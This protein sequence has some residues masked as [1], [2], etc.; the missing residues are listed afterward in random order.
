MLVA[1]ARRPWRRGRRPRSPR[2]ADPSPGWPGPPGGRRAGGGQEEQRGRRLQGED[3]RRASLIGRSARSTAGATSRSVH[4]SRS[5]GALRPAADEEQRPERVAAVQG[6]VAAAAGVGDAAPVDR[7]VAEREGDDE[8]ARVRR[9]QRRPDA[10]QR[11][12]VLSLRRRPSSTVASSTPG[13]PSSSQRPP[14][15][16]RDLAAGAEAQRS[17]PAR[18]PPSLARRHPRLAPRSGSPSSPSSQQ[19]RSTPSIS[20]SARRTVAGSA[21]L[22]LARQQVDVGGAA[23][24]ADRELGRLGPVLGG[25]QHRPLVGRAARPAAGRGGRR[26]GRG[27]RPGSARGRRGSRRG[28]RPPRPAARSSGRPWRSTRRVASGPWRCE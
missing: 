11:V 22:A 8:V 16:S 18:P 26:S 14:R 24:R 4:C 20:A 1:A 19:T 9:A 21:A 7:L 6:A 25:L 15:R 23:G 17:P 2:R 5:L 28:R 10:G 12:R 27:R 13:S 3:A